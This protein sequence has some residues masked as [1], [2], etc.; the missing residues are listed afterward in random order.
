[1][2]LAKMSTIGTALSVCLSHSQNV[3]LSLFSR[4]FLRSEGEKE[5]ET[6]IGKPVFFSSRR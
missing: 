2:S 4:S 5:R 1:M 3:C 6:E